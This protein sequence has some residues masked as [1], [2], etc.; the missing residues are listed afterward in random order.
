M[1]ADYVKDFENVETRSVTVCVHFLSFI[2]KFWKRYTRVLFYNDS[3]THMMKPYST[4]I[5][6]TN[7]P[8]SHVVVVQFI[9]NNIIELRI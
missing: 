1:S 3:Q 6:I 5:C 8:R 2:F 7:A 4:K 9:N